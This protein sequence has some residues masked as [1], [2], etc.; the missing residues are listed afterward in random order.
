MLP[1][2]VVLDAYFCLI[3]VRKRC[4]GYTLMIDIEEEKRRRA[5]SISLSQ[6]F[7]STPRK[8]PKK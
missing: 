3:F 2:V 4:L 6:F 7:A 8:S 1:I 5:S